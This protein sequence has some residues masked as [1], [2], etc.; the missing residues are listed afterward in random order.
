MES[1]RFPQTGSL[2]GSLRLSKP[3]GLT[4]NVVRYA[5][6][7]KHRRPSQNPP[8]QQVRINH[9]NFT[10]ILLCLNAHSLATLATGITSSVPITA[11]SIIPMRCRVPPSQRQ[12]SRF[13][14]QRRCSV[15]CKASPAGSTT[16]TADRM[17]DVYEALAERL[18]ESAAKTEPPQ[19]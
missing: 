10:S 18:L 14:T 15:K 4:Q 5:S 1:L 13:A 9:D 8:Q 12:T 6:C 7:R 2:A 17:A 11:H 16:I 19:K 3:H